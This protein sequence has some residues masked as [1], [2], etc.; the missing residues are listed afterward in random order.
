MIGLLHT[1][2][3]ILI[4]LRAY[5][6]MQNSEIEKWLANYPDIKNVRAVT[7]DIN[8]IM[9]GKRLPIT[10]LQKAVDGEL[11][12]PLSS[13]NLDIWGRDIANSK[14]VFESGDADGG[15]CWTGRGPL[16]MTWTDQN[17]AMVPLT[18]TYNDGQPFDG[19]PRNVL[20]A[21]LEKFAV[22]GLHPVAAFEMEFYLADPT[23]HDRSP[24]EVV[25]AP[26]TGAVNIRDG[27]LSV[28]DLNDYDTLLNDIYDCCSVQNV[29]AEA[30]ISE[31]GSGQFEI[32]LSHGSDC[33]KV[34]DDAVFFKQ[35]IK[36]VA[37]KHALAGSFMAK[38]YADRPGNGMHVHLSILNREGQN[39]FDD[40]S[41]KGSRLMQHAVAGLLASLP[42]SMLIFAPHNNSYRR[43]AIE[44]HAPTAACWGY[45]N[46][47]A[48]L[49]IPLGDPQNRR[50]EHR[51]AG[52]DANPYLLLAEFLA[53]VLAGFDEAKAP[54]PALEGSAY[55]AVLPTLP[56][57]W[58]AAQ[59]CFKKAAALGDLLP[60]VFRQM[61][62]DCKAQEMLRFAGD[63]S[64][65]EYQ[66]YLDQM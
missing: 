48:A 16:P 52:A 28:D 41:D 21:V 10:Q 49:R 59:D 44:S 23:L 6:I 56:T 65:F 26:L 57:K 35:I 12:I 47:T 15:S 45:E 20:A 46:R 4:K 33:L 60:A 37:R 25:V 18:L 51:V 32:N 19:D 24:P 3:Q 50:I 30:A 27:V 64:T 34:A 13:A 1:A 54:P 29:A 31:A 39:I 9:R 61:M 40:N 42:E 11:R 62:L 36:G 5:P 14:W 63:I 43:F 58:Q 17:A 2:L 8:G 53:G 38:P 22:R 55:D 7:F 66:S